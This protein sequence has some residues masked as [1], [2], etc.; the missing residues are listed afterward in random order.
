MDFNFN[1]EGLRKVEVYV[2]SVVLSSR[3]G[4]VQGWQRGQQSTTSGLPRVASSVLYAAL[5]LDFMQPD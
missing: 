2:C 4:N 5:D 3:S 1:V